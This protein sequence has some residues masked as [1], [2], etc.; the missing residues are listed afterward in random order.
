MSTT[1]AA[2]NSETSA[3]KNF[4]QIQNLI[5]VMETDITKETAQ[6]AIKEQ[7]LANLKA[8]IEEMTRLSLRP[9]VTG[10]Y[11]VGGFSFVF[12]RPF[13]ERSHD[14][15]KDSPESYHFGNMQDDLANALLGYEYVYEVNVYCIGTGRICTKNHYEQDRLKMSR[16]EFDDMVFVDLAEIIRTVLMRHGYLPPTFGQHFDKQIAD[17]LHD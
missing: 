4:E 14:Y 2:K 12:D 5:T 8:Y 9:L 17:Q 3:H 1:Q 11:E 13:L 10:G 16:K 7:N 15:K 6:L